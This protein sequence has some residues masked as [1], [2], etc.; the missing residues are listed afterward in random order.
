MKTTK[1]RSKKRWLYGLIVI[2]LLGAYSYWSYARTLPPIQPTPAHKTLATTA[3]ASKLA[4]PSVGQA[5]AG[6]VGSSRVVTHGSQTPVPT[7]STAKLI[8][9][10]TVLKAK[11]LAPGQSGP[12]ITLGPNDVAI[13]DMYVSEGGSRV[14]VVAGEQISEHQMLEAMLLPSADNMADSLAI[15]AFGSLNAYAKAA[16]DYLAQH[17]IRHTH[18]GTDASGLQPNTTSTAHDLVQLGKLTMQNPVLRQIVGEH[19]ASGIPVVNTVKNVNFLLGSDNIIGIKTGNSN[20]A[21]GVFVGA[22]QV[23]VAGKPTTVV[24]ALA[25][26]PTLFTALM[27][28]APFIKS[29]QADFHTVSIAKVGDVVGHYQLP[30]GDSVAAVVRKNLR[31]EAWDTQTIRATLKLKPAAASSQAGA[32]VGHLTIP[33]SALSDRQSVPVKLRASFTQPSLWWRMTHPFN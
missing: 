19:T 24:T 3:A 30:W 7:A 6:V 15:W 27:Y 18:V 13:Y 26:T 31:F 8:T 17:G 10:L 12:T 21:G 2:I 16:Q 29:A 4:W 5:A 9:A 28:S 23:T 1:R 32:V 33:S 11:P 25:H 14:R 22:A 20:Q